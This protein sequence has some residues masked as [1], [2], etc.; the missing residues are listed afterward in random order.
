VTIANDC[1]LDA[2]ARATEEAM[3]AGVAVIYQACFVDGDW[4]GFADFVERQQDGGYENTLG[5]GSLQSS[6]VRA[7]STLRRTPPS[8]N[9]A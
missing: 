7:P 6:Q 1:D 3:L 8:R 9:P 4:R 5:S 2:A